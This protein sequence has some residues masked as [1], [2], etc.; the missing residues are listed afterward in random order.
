MSPV[1]RRMLLL[2]GAGL[3]LVAAIVGCA[4]RPPAEKAKLAAST[5]KP[6]NQGGS[7]APAIPRPPAPMQL[8]DG[9]RYLPDPHNLGIAMDWGRG[10]AAN[11]PWAPVSIPNDFNPTV[12]GTSNGAAG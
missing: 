2:L 4:A 1:P 6:I 11:Q 9:W 10:G 8:S 5:Q 7:V 12:S 3:L